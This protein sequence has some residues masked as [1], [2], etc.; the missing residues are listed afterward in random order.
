MGL[1]PCGSGWSAEF[2]DDGGWVDLNL[3][4]GER[5]GEGFRV[6]LGLCGV[7]CYERVVLILLVGRRSSVLR[8]NVLLSPTFPHFLPAPSVLAIR[9]YPCGPRAPKM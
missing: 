3:H 8:R 9:V 5:L 2:V 1:G 7:F 6:D 4:R